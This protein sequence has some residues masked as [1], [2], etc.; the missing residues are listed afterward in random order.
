MFEPIRVSTEE[1][2]KKVTS[3]EAILVCAYEDEQKYRN[4]A[5]EGAI[6]LQEF[7]GKVETLTKTQEII[8]Y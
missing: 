4:A 6:S 2:N 8:F 3:H 5:L 1:A 7:R